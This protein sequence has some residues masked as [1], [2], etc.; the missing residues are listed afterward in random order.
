[1]R[2]LDGVLA[3]HRRRVALAWFTLALV[4]IGFLVASGS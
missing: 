2:R 3:R 4:V 1:M